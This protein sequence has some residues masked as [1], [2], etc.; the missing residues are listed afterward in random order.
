[1]RYYGKGQGNLALKCK[2][3][4]VL[5]NPSR[6]PSTTHSLVRIRKKIRK[7]KV[8]EFMDWG[9]LKTI[10]PVKQN[11]CMQAEQTIVSI[12]YFPLVGRC[13]VTPKEEGLITCNSGKDN[14]DHWKCPPI[15][16]SLPPLLLLSVTPCGIVLYPFGQSG[17]AELSVSLPSSWCTPRTLLAMWEAEKSLAFCKQCSATTRTSLCFHSYFYQKSKTQYHPRY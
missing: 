16:H 7:A 5:S 15:P 2:L 14:C 6:Q 10:Y 1:M 4:L 13:S 17:S 3:R 8:W 12:L 9:E 11:L